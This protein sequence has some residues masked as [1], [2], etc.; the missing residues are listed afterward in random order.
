MKKPTGLGRG[1]GSLIPNKAAATDVVAKEHQDLL[2]SDD[3]DKVL[4]ISV[5]KIDLNPMQPR[6]TFDHSELEELINSIR[7]HGIIQPLIVTKQA[8]RYELIAGERRLRAAKILDFKTVPCLVRDADEQ[9]K[10]ELALIEN[11][12]RQNLNPVEEAIAY[13]KLMG[14]FNLTQEEVSNKVGKSRPSIANTIRILTL[15]AEVQKALVDKKITEGHARVIAS[16][17]AEKEQLDFLNQILQYKFTV[18]DAEKESRKQRKKV[19]RRA[20]TDPALEATKEELREVLSTKVD[21]K[22]K[23]GKGQIIINFYSEEE[24]QDLIDKITT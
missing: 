15:P 5:D 4:Q 18:R 20:A 24:Y 3:A 8:N 17:E 6:Q 14:E 2:G 23:A 21:I 19:T 12:Q 13:Q 16:M 11:I 1:L 7:E 10:L 9:Q 22:K